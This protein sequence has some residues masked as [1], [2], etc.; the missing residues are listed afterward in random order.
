MLVVQR[1]CVKRRLRMALILLLA[2]AVL[3]SGSIPTFEVDRF[4]V[5]GASPA[6]AQEVPDP[7]ADD[8]LQLVPFANT[9]HR[10][11]SLSEDLWEVWVCRVPGWDTQIELEEV[12]DFLN[13]TVVPY[14]QELSDGRYRPAFQEGGRVESQ[15]EVT[16]GPGLEESVFAPG[17][18]EAVRQQAIARQEERN[19]E[20]TG[21]AG[22]LIVVEFEGYRT[23]YGTFGNLCPEVY[24]PGCEPSFPANRRLVV[25]GAGAVV[26]QPPLESPFWSLVVHEMGHAL[27]WPHSYSGKFSTT[28]PGALG[29]YDNPMDIMSNIPLT[30]PQGTT[31]YNRYASGWVDPSSVEVYWGGKQSYHLH[32]EGAAPGLVQMVVIPE[33]VVEGQVTE[34]VNPAG[35]GVFY[36]LGVRRLSGLDAGVPKV[37]VEVYRIDQ[38]REACGPSRR[39][40]PDH[41]P[42]FAVWTRV[43]QAVLPEFFGAVDHVISIDERVQLGNT[44]I[45]VVSADSVSFEVSVETRTSGA[46]LDDDGLTHESDIETIASLGITRGCG[47]RI[48][49]PERS[50]TRGEMSAFLVR[51][52][53]DSPPPAHRGLGAEAPWDGLTGSGDRVFSDVS[54]QNPF[55][56]HVEELAAWGVTIGYADGTFRPGQ[57]VTRGEMAVFLIRAFNIPT[58]D[59]TGIFDDVS[60]DAYYAS[61]TE[62]LYRLG[63]TSG[64]RPSVEDAPDG[65]FYFCPDQEVTRAQMASFLARSLA[66]AR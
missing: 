52:L 34:E 64:C 63:I 43:A 49:C 55:A 54:P 50:V 38:R 9:S 10:I 60:P 32:H 42:C 26:P 18:A 16:S 21:P 62:A 27:A 56:A 57:G 39:S 25:V 48:Y 14:F 8:P 29:F 4:S 40:W 46:F 47:V 1:A 65:L 7:R 45:R 5:G 24:Q 53:R 59:P 35:E 6:L 11:Y 41:W 2:T 37:G 66:I 13:A 44:R 51:A 12:V 61:A 22:A 3:W 19:P 31:V 36:V 30:A 20:E 15:D 23:G 33:R 28:R 58:T 17:C